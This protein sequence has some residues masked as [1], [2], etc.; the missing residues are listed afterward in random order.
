HALAL[1]REGY[2]HSKRDAGLSSFSGTFYGQTNKG[3]GVGLA[4][5]LSKRTTVYAG[6]SSAKGETAGTDVSK[7]QLYAVGLKHTF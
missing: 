2:A 1:A 7:R 3:F 5:L 6:V 4:Y